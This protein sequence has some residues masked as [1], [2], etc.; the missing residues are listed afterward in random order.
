VA[1][2]KKKASQRKAAAARNAQSRKQPANGAAPDLQR[3][4]PATQP[5]PV[6]SPTQPAPT[7][8][9]TQPAP[10][11]SSSKP[12]PAGLRRSQSLDLTATKSP[13]LVPSQWGRSGSAPD[14]P[15][16]PA[17]APTTPK[18]RVPRT[19]D[20]A[21]ASAATQA[22]ANPATRS[23]VGTAPAM[24]PDSTEDDLP[25]WAAKV[26]EEMLMLTYW[27]DPGEHGDPFTATIRFTG[28][29]KNIAGK[30]QPGDTFAQDETVT[31]VMPGSGPVAIT[32]EVRGVTAGEWSITAQPVSRPGN[33]KFRPYAPPGDEEAG[34]GRVPWPRRVRV[35]AELPPTVHTTRLLRTKVPGI[36]RPAYATLVSLGVLVGLAVETLLLHI[37][38]YS[39]FRPLL[40]SLAGVAA[41]AVGGKAWYVAVQG[42]KKFDGWCIQGFVAG[43]A[44]VIAVAAIVGPGMPAAALLSVAAPALLIGMAI[45]RPGC[46][47]AGCCTG[48]PTAARWGI[49]SSDRHLGCR[50]EPAQ[51]LEALSAL[52][53]GVAVLCVVLLAGFERSGPMAAA[54]LAAYTLVRQF[55][56]GM[57]AEA[58]RWRYGRR[59]TGAIAAMALIASI[60]LFAAG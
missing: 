14:G 33:G 27:I 7:A 54:A 34:G 60:A 41:G 3:P 57:R 4:A 59:V 13:P 29:R 11:A 52:I 5:V 26:I 56:V 46:F 36:T 48:R 58:R 12:V 55:I 25:A 17:P 23:S 18:V 19:N 6:S 42:G 43:A 37:G 2:S 21:S 28:R 53:I 31:G 24:E 10:A 47:W 8:S 50:R 20:Q 35:P 22:S 1:Q 38:H 49:W 45:G 32:T 16:G 9:P 39:A 51:L 40:Y 44:A 15:R 30:P